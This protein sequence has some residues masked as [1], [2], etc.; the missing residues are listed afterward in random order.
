VGDAQALQPEQAIPVSAVSNAQVQTAF[1]EQPQAVV[2]QVV[3]INATARNQA[4]AR[5]L[6]VIG[7]AAVLGLVIVL[8][9]PKRDRA[10][11]ATEES[12][13]APAS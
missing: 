2:D 11:T 1:Q 4:L 10:L 12:P 3:Q 13:A 7:L 6:I 5:A 8:L 9:S